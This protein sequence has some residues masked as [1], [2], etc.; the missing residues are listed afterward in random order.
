MNFSPKGIKWRQVIAIAMIAVPWFLRDELAGRMDQR[1]TDAQQVLTEKDNQE[2]QQQQVEDQRDM[3]RRIREIQG[4]LKVVD[5][6]LDPQ[7]TEG[8][9]EDQA[10]KSDDEFLDGYFKEAASD[11]A[12]GADKLT[13]LMQRVGLS[14][15]QK[16]KLDGAAAAAHKTA[17]DLEGFNQDASEDEIDVLY[18]NLGESQSALVKAYDELSTVADQER[19][20]STRNAEIARGAAWVL[21]ALATVLMGNWKRLLG[22]LDDEEKKADTD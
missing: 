19:A 16:Q 5:V 18:K 11:L 7:V 6:K 14:S 9:I 8:Q 1:A 12:D 21:T 20:R 10:R 2:E 4:Q 3:L 17:H 22:G 15:D 13:D